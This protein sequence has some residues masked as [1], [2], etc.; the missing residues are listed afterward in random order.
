MIDGTP[1]GLIQW[2]EPT[3]PWQDLANA[4]LDHDVVAS[5]RYIAEIAGVA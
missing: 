3:D 5:A 1:K 2:Q 4:E